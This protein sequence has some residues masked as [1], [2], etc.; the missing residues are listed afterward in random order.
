MADKRSTRQRLEADLRAV[1]ARLSEECGTGK[2]RS[3]AD[4]RV[5]ATEAALADAAGVSTVVA[6]I[7]RSTRLRAGQA[8]GWP[9]VSWLAGCAPT[10]SSGSISTSVRRDGS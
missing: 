3:L 10:P 6:A 7:E 5:Q 1:A 2:P 9:L 8:T 4:Q